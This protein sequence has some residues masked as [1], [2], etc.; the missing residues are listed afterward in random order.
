MLFSLLLGLGNYLRWNEEWIYLSEQMISLPFD[1][2]RQLL[3]QIAITHPLRLSIG[4]QIICVVLGIIGW[5]QFFEKRS[6]LH[7]WWFPLCL[8]TA[9][10]IFGS[11]AVW[12]IPHSNAQ[13]SEA[14]NVD[15]EDT[16]GIIDLPAEV[17]TSMET[18]I[19]LFSQ[20]MVDLSIHPR[21]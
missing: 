20:N 13:I 16:R 21:C 7:F 18:P 1:W 15:K 3:P 5:K 10:S 9:E 4:G 19:F 14:Y 8:I 6:I 2:I 17:G 11:S 12:P